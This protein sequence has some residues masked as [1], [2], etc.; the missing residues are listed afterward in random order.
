MMPFRARIVQHTQSYEARVRALFGLGPKDGPGPD[1]PAGPF[2]RSSFHLEEHVMIRRLPD[3]VVTALRLRALNDPEFNSVVV[4]QEL[5]ER[6][7]S[8]RP[9]TVR[10]AVTGHSHRN[11]A[12]PPVVRGTYT[13]EHLLR[14]L[15][16]F[17]FVLRRTPTLQDL[18][19]AED[20]ASAHTYARHFGSWSAAC[21]AAGLTP[22]EQGASGHVGVDIKRRRVS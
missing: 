16:G 15:R 14:A 19:Q 5:R 9:V 1:G 17:A 11:N 4:A 8:V 12:T 2:N 10:A 20:M 3:H 6:G 7:Y 21:R 22:R 18:E 13:R